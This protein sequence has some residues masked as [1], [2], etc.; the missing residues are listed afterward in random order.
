VCA[1]WDGFHLYAAPP[2]PSLRPRTPNP[3]W[4][5]ELFAPRT[6]SS[7]VIAG[8][9]LP[10]YAVVLER[11]YWSWLQQRALPLYLLRRPGVAGPP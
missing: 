9:R 4:W 1:G 6:D 5:A 2:S 3:P 8:D 10:G 7:Y 11:S